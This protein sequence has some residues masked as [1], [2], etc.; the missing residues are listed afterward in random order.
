MTKAIRKLLVI[1]EFL[2][3]FWYEL[4]LANLRLAHDSLRPTRE[5]RPGIIAVPLD[6]ETA[7]QITVL[8]NL[9]TLTPG[10]LSLDVSPDR[11]T[12]YVHAMDASD[13]ERVRANIKRG[14]ERRV[15]ELFS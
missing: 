5:L 10:T 14:L 1:A 8:S 9:I 6:L 11:K 3:Y 2:A 13:I 15:K 7:W 12:I 4:I